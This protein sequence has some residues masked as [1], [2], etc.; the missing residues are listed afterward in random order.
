MWP[1]TFRKLR[2]ARRPDCRWPTSLVRPHLEPLE[3]RTVLS[4]L[5]PVAYAVDPGAVAVATGDFDRD[6]NLD[7]VTANSGSYTLSVLRGRGDGSF[8]QAV[9]VSLG[10]F[11]TAD[12]VA[13]ADVNAD[14]R[15]DLVAGSQF[16]TFSGSS[17]Y[18][19]GV[20]TVTPTV[21]L[22]NGDGTFRPALR[23]ATADSVGLQYSLGFNIS[24][25]PSSVAVG[26]F[27]RDGTIDLA[28]SSGQRSQD[29]YGWDY[30]VWDHVTV[31]LGHGDGTFTPSSQATVNGGHV[32]HGGVQLAVGDVNG[33]G[34]PDVATS[35][36]DLLLGNGDGTVRLTQTGAAGNDIAVADFNGDARLDLAAVGGNAQVF[37][38]NG[39]GTFQS[40]ASYAVLGLASVAVADFNGDGKPDLLT[41]GNS[42]TRVATVLLNSGDGTFQSLPPSPVGST[43]VAVAVGDFN[44]DGRVDA[45]TAN[46]AANTATILINDGNWLPSPGGPSIAISDVR[47]AEGNVGT[48][49]FTF[50]VSLSF[51][52]NQWVTVYFATADG[53]ANVADGDYVAQSG[54]LTFAPGETTKTITVMVKGDGKVEADETFSVNL[55]GAT[56]A[57]VGDGKGI[58]TILNDDRFKGK[59]H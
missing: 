16:R 24:S 44:G 33:D 52:S 7:L 3:E 32:S 20:A 2:R 41:A 21:F 11:W 8:R 22:G 57:F 29:I 47:A 51:A 23:T 40:P 18:Y 45:A 31:L 54:T 48:T 50:V 38:G 15:L 46:G 14:G 58:G 12:S 25:V 19:S 55:S 30:A 13:V 10:G 53:T 43:P 42:T 28:V 27:N 56:N 35:T 6:G 1:R 39:D 34:V 59:P 36:G 9:S 26:D 49:L 17:G 5:A 37:L 4:F